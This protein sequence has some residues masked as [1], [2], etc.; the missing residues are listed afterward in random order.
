MSL[1]AEKYRAEIIKRRVVARWRFKR[2]SS[3]DHRKA[4]KEEL[5]FSGSG[6]HPLSAQY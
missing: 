2:F 6:L 4:R 5:I 1:P 3:A